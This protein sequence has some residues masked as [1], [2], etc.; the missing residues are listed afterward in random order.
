MINLVNTWNT[1][2]NQKEV[3]L[4][5]IILQKKIITL[6][7]HKNIQI[8]NLIFMTNPPSGFF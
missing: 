1:V 6:L 2:V 4:D 5:K 7:E 8:L 3:S